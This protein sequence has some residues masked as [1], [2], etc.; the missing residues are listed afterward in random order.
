M[1]MIGS[2]AIL[3]AFGFSLISVGAG[4]G[5]GMNLNLNPPVFVDRFYAAFVD[6]DCFMDIRNRA[7]ERTA[8]HIPRAIGCRGTNAAAWYCNTAR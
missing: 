7:D 6:W 3:A 4:S 2:S 5:H 1:P 8:A